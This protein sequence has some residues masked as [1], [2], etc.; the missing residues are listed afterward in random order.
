MRWAQQFT[1]INKM[2]Y[3]MCK[4]FLIVKVENPLNLKIVELDKAYIFW[5]SSVYL[6]IRQIKIHRNFREKNE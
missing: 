6:Q 1:A 3:T 2:F 4:S 5:T